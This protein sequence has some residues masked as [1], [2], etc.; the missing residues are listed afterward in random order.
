MIFC[1][2]L[3]NCKKEVNIDIEDSTNKLEL[4]ESNLIVFQSIRFYP[5]NETRIFYHLDYAQID[6]NF[7]ETKWISP[8]NSK[9]GELNEITIT[10]DFDFV[11]QIID[12]VSGSSKEISRKISVDTILYNDKFDY[13]NDYLGNYKFEVYSN[14]Y[15]VFDDWLD[16]RDT[17]KSEGRI[18]KFE[19]YNTTDG[20]NYSNV[21]FKISIIYSGYSLERSDSRCG[22]VVYYTD[23]FLHPTINSIGILS[24]PE[25]EECS[26]I[27]NGSFSN[28][29]LTVEYRY[30]NKWDGFSR[31][32]VGIKIKNAS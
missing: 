24:Y 11:I 5:P 14:K 16:H 25:F 28:D 18:E 1:I 20:S 10:A 12:K 30:Q 21:N 32:I 8:I 3:S 6:T 22:T 7:F 17:L 9:S 27:F 4:F 31:K 23:G 2:V 19:G 13:R 26:G 29:T 15:D